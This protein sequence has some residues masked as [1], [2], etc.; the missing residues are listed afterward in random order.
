MSY[1]R[2][3]AIKPEWLKLDELLDTVLI[4]MQKEINENHV[5]IETDY[6]A[7]LPNIYAD[8]RKLRQI[9]NNVIGNAIQAAE[10]LDNR[11]PEISIRVKQI[12][13]VDIP[14][15]CIEITDNGHGLE[16]E[17]A[18]EL[19]EPFFT[20]RSKGTGLGLAIVSRFVEQHNGTVCLEPADNGGTKVVIVLPTK[21]ADHYQIKN[22]EKMSVTR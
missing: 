22:N 13:S 2:P 3:D 1:S 4:H 21:P 16:P 17:I 11:I 6:Q 7:G 9:F 8:E 19:F 18:G 5:Q 12:M 10:G 20:T 15:V 14:E